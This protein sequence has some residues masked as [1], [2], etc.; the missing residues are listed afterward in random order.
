MSDMATLQTLPTE[1]LL[2]IISELNYTTLYKVRLTSSK[3]YA[4]V[5]SVPIHF[6]SIAVPET[7]TR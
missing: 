5:E 2:Q 6:G 7:K 3:M 1:L 4:L